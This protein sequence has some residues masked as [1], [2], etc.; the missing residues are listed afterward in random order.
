ME[1]INLFLTFDYELPLGGWTVSPEAA[2]IEPTRKLLVCCEKLHVRAVFFIDVLS[3]IRFRELENDSFEQSVRRQ[4]TEIVRQGH[5]IQL[6]LHPHWFTSSFENGIYKPSKDF[7]LADFNEKEIAAMVAQGI[8]Y[9]NDVAKTVNPDYTCLAFRA[10][11]FNLENSPM[12]FKILTE[13]GIQI[14]SS[15]CHGYYFAS[16]ISTVDYS[17]LPN[18]S[19][20]F[21]THGN[22][23]V[24]TCTGMYEIPIAGKKKSILEVPTFIK[25]NFLRDRMPENRGKVIHANHKL[26]FQKK[27][28]KALS[29]RMLSFDNYT[30]S[31]RFLMNILHDNIKRFSSQEEISLA[32]IS[33]PKTMDWYNYQLMEDVI[34]SAKKRYGDQLVFTTFQAFVKK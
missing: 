20:W 19:N 18:Q 5:D 33:H 27:I 16:D 10:G 22:Y 9:L 13:N 23:N 21:F 2:L 25:V 7:R 14:D 30:C 28:K 3:F 34:V 26:S 24:P 6:H 8:D 32:I 15:L 12:I 31:A 29:A 1:R 4:L 17:N 11:G